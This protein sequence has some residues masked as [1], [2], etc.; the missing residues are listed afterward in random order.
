MTELN[1][2]M[3]KKAIQRPSP[4]THLKVTLPVDLTMQLSSK[5]GV[6]WMPEPLPRAII[7]GGRDRGRGRGWQFWANCEWLLSCACIVHECPIPLSANKRRLCCCEYHAHFRRLRSV[8]PVFSPV[9]FSEREGFS[10]SPLYFVSVV[11]F[12]HCVV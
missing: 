8:P 10:V 1:V 6:D 5:L 3:Y 2:V 11:L 12:Y 9:S 4:C 7:L